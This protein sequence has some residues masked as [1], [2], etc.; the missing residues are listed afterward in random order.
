MIKKGI[1]IN[2]ASLLMMGITFKENCPDVRNT[3]IV[4]V[5]NA[6]ADYGIKVTIYDPMADPSEVKHEYGLNTLTILPVQQFDAVIMGVAH[7][8]FLELD[9]ALLQKQI[10]VLYDVKGILGTEVDGRL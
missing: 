7:K 10:S 9:L 8:D 4:D 5:V 3:K 6:I 1:V 2:G